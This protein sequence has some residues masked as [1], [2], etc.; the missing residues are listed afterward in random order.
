[1]SLCLSCTS[2]GQL[3]DC[4]DYS[5][6]NFVRTGNI[7][8][9]TRDPGSDLEDSA[10]CPVFSRVSGLNLGRRVKNQDDPV[11]YHSTENT[12]TFLALHQP[13]ASSLPA[14]KHTSLLLKDLSTHLTG[15]HLVTTIIQCSDFYTVDNNSNRRDS[16]DDSNHSAEARNL[17]LLCMIARPQVWSRERLCGQRKERFKN[18]RKHFHALLNTHQLA[19]TSP[20]LKSVNRMEKVTAIKFFEG[21][22]GLKFLRNYVCSRLCNTSAPSCLLYNVDWHRN[23]LR[24]VPLCDANQYN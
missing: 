15:K 2:H 19:G 9:D 10:K 1:M 3:G 17:I 22:F 12:T 13:E 18:I 21:L 8:E 5:N 23:I 16:G 20:S 14:N 7:F 24:E 6:G 4:G 11:A